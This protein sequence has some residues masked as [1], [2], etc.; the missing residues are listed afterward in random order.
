MRICD[1][2][3]CCAGPGRRRGT[4]LVLPVILPGARWR[5]TPTGN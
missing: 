5:C 4:A 1:S 3:S 2:F